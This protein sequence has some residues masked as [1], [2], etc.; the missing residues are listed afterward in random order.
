MGIYTTAPPADWW[1]QRERWREAWEHLGAGS[2]PEAWPPYQFRGKPA[3]TGAQG[4]L[5]PNSEKPKLWW[6]WLEL[7]AGG[8]AK[9]DLLGAAMGATKEAAS[10]AIGDLSGGH[11]AR[12]GIPVEITDPAGNWSEEVS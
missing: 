12:C 4:L 5:K 3:C 1:E 6:E 11:E 9:A 10:S 8:D 7:P 2:N